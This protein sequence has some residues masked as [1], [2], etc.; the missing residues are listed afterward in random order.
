MYGARLHE[1]TVWLAALLVFAGVLGTARALGSQETPGSTSKSRFSGEWR[2]GYFFL[3]SR[4]E[5]GGEVLGPGN[6]W[7]APGRGVTL[8]AVPEPGYRFVSWKG[9]VPAEARESNPVR[10]V[11]DGNRSLVAVFASLESRS[12]P[13]GDE[14]RK[15]EQPPPCRSEPASTEKPAPTN[16]WQLVVAGEPTPQGRSWPYD[17]GIHGV[18]IGLFVTNAVLSS[19]SGGK[20]VRF[21]CQGWTGSGSIPVSGSGTS[22]VFTVTTNSA[23]VW[24][25]KKQYWINTGVVLIPPSNLPLSAAAGDM[26]AQHAAGQRLQQA[27]QSSDSEGGL[28]GMAGFFP[29][30][31]GG[32]VSVPS[33]WYDADSDVTLVAVASN[34]YDFVRWFG[35]VDGSTFTNNPLTVHLD[36]PLRVVAG[37][38]R[39]RAVRTPVHFVALSGGHRYPYGT[40]QD[41]ARD[42]QAAVDAADEGD[43]ILVTNGTY[44]ISKEITIDRGVV[45]R[46]V[47]GPMSTLVQAAGAQRCFKLSAPKTLLAGFTI[48]GGRADKGGGIWADRQVAIRDCIVI[49]NEAEEGGGIY[50]EGGNL[51][52]NCLI[53]ENSARIGGGI[54]AS[55]YNRLENCTI[56]RN[57]ADGLAGGF[58]GRW[59]NSIVNSILHQNVASQAANWFFS[60]GDQRFDFAGV[61]VNC[62]FNCSEPVMPGRGNI[63][64]DPA[65]V[66]LTGGNYRLRPDSPCVDRAMN[67]PWM[68]GAV[69]LDASPRISNRLADMG[70]YEFSRPLTPPKVRLLVRGAPEPHGMSV[71]Y[72][73]GT[74]MLV[75]GTVVTSTVVTPAPDHGVRFV[76]VGWTGTGSVPA[77]GNGTSVAY[78]VTANSSITWHWKRQYWIETGEAREKPVGRLQENSEHLG[79]VHPASGWFDRGSTLTV[80][81]RPLSGAYFSGWRGAVPAELRYENPLTV[82]VDRPLALAACFLKDTD[83]DGLSDEEEAVAGTSP[84]DPCDVLAIRTIGVCR[85]T[86]PPA[87]FRQMAGEAAEGIE[88][89]WPTVKGRRYKIMATDNLRRGF[90]VVASNIP[91]MSGQATYTDRN[92]AEVQRR[93]YRI[94]VEE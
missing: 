22:V 4:A 49:G 60:E 76:C 18:S 77:S 24:Q 71:P 63:D 86:N 13:E 25:W 88:I 69:D 40:W 28:S 48:T 87:S 11:M 30:A 3:Y 20:G 51:V 41:A 50:C 73:Y 26:P 47:N 36:R 84:T 58:W 53:A 57:R 45:V 91:G 21:V 66:D 89:A 62:A 17:Y 42:I 79:E 93:F 39:S 54:F 37:F 1:R 14:I 59:G 61:V 46:S 81:A 5:V 19:V 7:Y 2:E 94:V 31:T 68:P 65:F 64:G 70:V 43:T 52:R 85:R 9:D 90:Y 74:H 35:D 10:L 8:A 12:A 72:D 92:F 29:V 34:G 44:V 38:V 56:A 82:T 16:V 23:L 55:G 75:A 6:G 83:D 33:G 32:R 15:Q 67:L 78:T 80:T 27:C